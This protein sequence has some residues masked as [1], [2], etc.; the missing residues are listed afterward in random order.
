LKKRSTRIKQLV[1]DIIAHQDYERQKEQK[2]SS[3]LESL[4]SGFKFVVMLQIGVLVAAAI[5]SVISLRK[6]FVRKHIY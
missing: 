5:F 3:N 2:Y 6:F 1:D 4:N